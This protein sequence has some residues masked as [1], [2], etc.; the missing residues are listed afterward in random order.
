MDHDIKVFFDLR[1]VLHVDCAALVERK[2]LVDNLNTE[3]LLRDL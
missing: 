1:K 2:V 3:R